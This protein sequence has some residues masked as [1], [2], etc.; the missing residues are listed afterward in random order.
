MLPSTF[1]GYSPKPRGVTNEYS[2]R[3][4]Q[5]I[6]RARDRGIRVDS[7]Q[8]GDHIT[9]GG[10]SRKLNLLT[11]RSRDVRVCGRGKQSQITYRDTRAVNPENSPAGRLRNELREMFLVNGDRT[12]RRQRKERK[13]LSYDAEEMRE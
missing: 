10:N 2:T 5:K 13:D 11:R 1:Q 6:R 8:L 12:S 4:H 9:V 7:P 3:N